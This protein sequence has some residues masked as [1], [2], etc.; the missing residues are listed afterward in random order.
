MRKKKG[1]EKRAEKKAKGGMSFIKI[2]SERIR[3]GSYKTLIIT[4]QKKAS[5]SK[6]Q[7]GRLINTYQKTW[8]SN[9]PFKKTSMN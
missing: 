5:K 7:G 9:T 4:S 2:K 1:N 3:T 8:E 6:K